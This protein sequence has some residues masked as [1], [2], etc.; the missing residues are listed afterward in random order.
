MRRLYSAQ[1]D[2]GTPKEDMHEPARE[3]TVGSFSSRR[4]RYGDH[5]ERTHPTT[6]P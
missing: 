1:S 5:T 6:D 2:A 3:L 4:P